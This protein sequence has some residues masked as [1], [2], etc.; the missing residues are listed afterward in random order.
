MR[1]AAEERHLRLLL[2]HLAGH[3]VRRRIELDD[4]VQEVYLRM[5]RSSELPRESGALRALLA[6]V[7]RNTVIDAARA[8]RA[9]KRSG[10][11]VRLL[12]SDWSGAG[13]RAGELAARTPG[14]ATRARLSEEEGHLLAAFEGLSAEHRRVIGLRQLEGLSARDA[15]VRLGRSETAVHS[16]YRRALE[17][18]A[19]LAGAYSPEALD[20]S[21]SPSR[22]PPA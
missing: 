7:A 10:S 6:H 19:E 16:L 15:A 20:E 11:E 8:I 21:R 18:W 1:L 14:P 4:L 12:R 9:A 2:A 22:S 13:E 5:L 17:R 3:A